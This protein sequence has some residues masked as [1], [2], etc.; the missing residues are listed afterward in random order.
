MRDGE[1]SAARRTKSGSLK[2]RRR[3]P[4]WHRRL[5]EEDKDRDPKY[6]QEWVNLIALAVNVVE[7]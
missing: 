2:V 4:G 5:L 3:A 1:E 7:C 6:W